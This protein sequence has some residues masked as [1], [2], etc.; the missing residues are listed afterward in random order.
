MKQRRFALLALA[1]L[2]ACGSPAATTQNPAPTAAAGAGTAATSAAP[3]IAEATGVPVAKTTAPAATSAA[4]TAPAMTA[5][6]TAMADHGAMTTA[7]AMTDHGAMMSTPADLALQL[8]LMRGHL[9]VSSELVAAGDFDAAYI[10]AS[11]PGGEHYFHIQSAVAAADAALDQRASAALKAHAD[12]VKAKQSAAQIGTARTAAQAALDQIEAK[13]VTDRT[14]LD[15]KL[16]ATLLNTA[17]AEYAEGVK[18]G[19]VVELEE[20]QDAV[21]FT[22]RAQERF[23]ASKAQLDATQSQVLEAALTVFGTA[24]PSATAPATVVPAEA[25]SAAAQALTAVGFLGGDDVTAMS[26]GL[27]A[28]SAPIAQIVSAGQ[29]G[30]KEQAKVGFEVFEEGWAAIE[31]GVRARSPESYKAIEA[32]MGELEDAAVRA[33]VPDAATVAA[34]GVALEAAITAFVATLGSDLQ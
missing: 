2:T 19:K 14:G 28:L 4:T 11:H 27:A 34:K 30:D 31:D 7:T 3:T 18:D 13:I 24:T 8:D 25:L 23:T 32:A 29:A 20:Y 9:L 16:I 5:A 33:D 10:H 22:R 17:A 15:S 12:A 26:T 6:A 1:A 21:G